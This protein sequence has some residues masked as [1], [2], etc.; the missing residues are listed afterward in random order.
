MQRLINKYHASLLIV[1]R[2][3]ILFFCSLVIN[4]GYAQNQESILNKVFDY[5]KTAESYSYNCTYNM[6]RGFT[7]NIITESY[8]GT[9]FKDGNISRITALNSEILSYPNAQLTISN[10]S[11]LIIY[12]KKRVDFV[13]KSPVDISLFLKYFEG[14]IVSQ[15]NNI[16]K[17]EMTLTKNNFQIPYQK[18][19]FYINK[20]NYSL[21]RQELFFATKLPFKNAE[22]E[23]V[24][25]FGRMEIIFSPNN[26]SL[27]NIKKIEDFLII[28]KDT[29]KLTKAYQ[30]YQLIDQSN[31]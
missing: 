15:E 10:D 3:S 1:R 4:F 2:L 16:I 29:I 21:I 25:D 8:K 14:N 12:I 11:K 7:G 13:E 24:N 27:K 6:Y 22:G 9:I 18:V 28:E 20:T 17:Y 31:L 5:Y 26:H 19:V 23:S 30:N